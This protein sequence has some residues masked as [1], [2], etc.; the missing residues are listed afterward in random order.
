MESEV[1]GEER[2]KNRGLEIHGAAKPEIRLGGKRR[3][4]PSQQEENPKTQVPTPGHPA[5]TTRD[6]VTQIGHAPA[7]RPDFSRMRQRP[8]FGA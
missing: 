2:S 6:E 3:R 7:Q 8:I 5:H 1:R 4:Y